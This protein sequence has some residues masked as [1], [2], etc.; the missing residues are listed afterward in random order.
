[1]ASSLDTQ[2]HASGPDLWNLAITVGKV[3]RSQIASF[4]GNLLVVFPMTFALAWLYHFTFGV[5]IASGAAA[6]K[7]LSDQHPYESL[8]LLYACFTGFFLFLSG[9]I[10]GYIENHV[11]YGR[12][13]ERLRDHPVF[14]HTLSTKWLNKLARFVQ[15]SAGGFAG[16]VMLGLFLGVAGPLG[17]FLGVHFDIRHITI[18]AGNA[19]IGLYG[20]GYKNV[21][22]SYL[23]VVL[24]GVLLIGVLNF[25]VSFSLAFFVAVK[26][27]GIK[28]RDYPEF[29]GILLRYFRKH[30]LDFIFPP[31]VPR[32]SAQLKGEPNIEKPEF[33]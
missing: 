22:G 5:K 11:V 24:G 9:L 6:M 29:L 16:S 15:N 13:G 18:A 1:V 17:K 33:N 12:V 31:R 21:P 28:L 4:A 19:S 2:K 25:L 32:T 26:S 8:S 10:A 30:P 20:V 14:T 27:R 3:A 7:L 23:A